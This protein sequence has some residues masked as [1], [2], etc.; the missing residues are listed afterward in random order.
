MA[1]YVVSLPKIMKNTMKTIKY[2]A[3]ALMLMPFAASAQ[4]TVQKTK[5][6]EATATTAGSEAAKYPL[7]DDAEAATL[8]KKWIKKTP[9][10]QSDYERVIAL[11]DASFYYLTIELQE[12]CE[13]TS[14]PTKRVELAT[15]LDKGITSNMANFARTFSLRLQKLADQGGLSEEN[16]ASLVVM[17]E[18]KQIYRQINQE[19]YH[20]K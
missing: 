10:T 13:K 5:S 6:T 8:W 1:I 12:I 20:P 19:V 4:K 11:S 15:E 2:L 16:M 18:K 17:V 7:Y 14:S 9:F 3:I